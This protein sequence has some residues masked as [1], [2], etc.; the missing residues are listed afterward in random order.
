MCACLC[1]RVVVVNIISTVYLFTVFF[2]YGA[3]G[4]LQSNTLIGLLL[5]AIEYSQLLHATKTR[6][7][8]GSVGHLWVMSDCTS[9]LIEGLGG[10]QGVSDHLALKSKLNQCTSTLSFRS[11]TM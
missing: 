8:F 4:C 3:S 11:L 1:Q 10:Q 9:V 2:I 6:F 5:L 7:S